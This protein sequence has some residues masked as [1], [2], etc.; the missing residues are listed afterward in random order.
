MNSIGAAA[1][2]LHKPGG[3]QLRVARLCLD[4]E[5]IHDSQQCPVCASETFAYLSKWVPAPERRAKARPPEPPKEPPKVATPKGLL[6]GIGALGA[7]A[8]AISLWSRTIRK[9]EDAA[10]RRETGELR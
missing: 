4:C 2:R 7:I 3:M 8:Y 6:V 9:F 10:S 1:F 5:E